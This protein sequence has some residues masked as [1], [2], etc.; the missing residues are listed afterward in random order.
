MH[1]LIEQFK[2]H[3][4]K[5]KQNDDYEQGYQNHWVIEIRKLTLK[6]I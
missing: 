4:V 6:I 3:W 5:S 2:M 1:A